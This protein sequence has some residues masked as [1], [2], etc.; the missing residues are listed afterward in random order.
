MIRNAR[1]TDLPRIKALLQEHDL[2]SED[3]NEHLQHFLVYEK[4]KSIIAVGGGE[5]YNDVGLIRSIAVAASAQGEGI[6]SLLVN[7]LIRN[8]KKVT[9]KKVYLLTTTAESYFEKK[10]FLV[11]KREDVPLA[12]QQTKQF[13]DL[14]PGSATVMVLDIC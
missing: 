5:Y 10:H 11:V 1:L 2:P 6:A 3:C 14:C 12:I 7:A 4:D 8:M 9:I 13:S